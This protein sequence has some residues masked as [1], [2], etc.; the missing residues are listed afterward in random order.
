MLVVYTKNGG[1]VSGKDIRIRVNSKARKEFKENGYARYRDYANKQ[2]D[3]VL[4]AKYDWS[5]FERDCSALG[6]VDWVYMLRKSLPR[7]SYLH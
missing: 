2:A 6:K 3:E 7:L 4:N 1:K 5:V